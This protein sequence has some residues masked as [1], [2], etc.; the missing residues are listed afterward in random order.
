MF[1]LVAASTI[2]F[3]GTVLYLALRFVRAAERRGIERGELDALRAR[4]AQMEEEMDVTRTELE[5][6]AAAESHTMMLLT[7]RSKAPEQSS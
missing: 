6:L 3:W 2:A 1:F 4:V 5:R 7:R